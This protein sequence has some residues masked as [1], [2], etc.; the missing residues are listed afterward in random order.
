[1]PGCGGYNQARFLMSL[2]AGTSLGPYEIVAPVGAGGMGEVYRARDTRLG[3]DVAIKILPPRLASDPSA[4]ARFEQEARAV[5]ALSHPNIL[6]IHDVGRHDAIAFVVIELLDGETLRD[7]MAHGRVPL[8]KAVEYAVQM[9]QG[10]AAAHTKGITHRD[11]KPENVFVTNDGHVKILDF[12]LAKLQVMRATDLTTT[13]HVPTEPGTVLGT[14]GYLSPEQAQGRPV[15]PRSDIFSLG[16]VL[17][18]MATGVRAFKGDSTID[19]LHRII[20]SEPAP[21]DTVVPDAPGE[22]RWVL[23]KCLAKDPDDRYQSTRDLV[24]D[25]RNVMRALESS[26]RVSAA[27]QTMEAVPMPRRFSG[28][29]TAVIAAVLLVAAAVP[30]ALWWQSRGAGA[31][32]ADADADAGRLS[33]EPVTTLGTVIDAV[34][35]PDGK[36]VA[37]VVSENAQQSLW[38][39]Q[40][41]TASTLQ[42]VP[43]A[44]VGYWGANFSLDGSTL[45]Y[46]IASDEYPEKALFRI[47][48]LG[49]A[50]RKL[51]TGLDSFPVFAPDGRQMAYMRASYPEPGASALMVASID[52]ANARALATR[53]AP[54][55]F[56]P[57]FFTAPAWSPDGTM[58]VCPMVRRGTPTTATL[59]AVKA[60]DGSEMPFPHYEWA[61]IG[62]ATWMPDGTGLV[63]VGG[64]EGTRSR[65]NQLWWVSAR[66]VSR[67]KITNDLLDYRTV[68]LPADGSTIMTVAA[69]ATSS[70]WSAPLDGSSDVRRISGGRYDGLAGLA[71]APG[72]RIVYRSV[73]GGS[74]DLWIMEA[75]GTKRNPLTAEGVPASPALTPDGLSIVFE[76]EDDGLWQ[77]GLDG[78]GLRPV[79]ETRL[80][81]SPAVTPDGKWILY[82]VT[83]SGQE[84]LWKVPADGSAAPSRMLDTLSYGPAVSPDGTRVAFYFRKSPT[85]PYQLAVMRLDADRPEMTF[86][87]VPSS[88]YAGVRWTFDGKALLHNS[89]VGDRSNIWLQP[90]D[91]SPARKVTNFVDQNIM[92]FDRSVDGKRLIIARGVLSRDAVMIRHFR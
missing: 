68:S 12:G 48:I 24:V 52:G 50:A 65:P 3:R 55:F 73:E 43:P 36:Y 69:D 71:A 7:R 11:I 2:A 78:Q 41:A 85:S 25:L 18:E 59:V 54:E 29:Q 38:L 89:S 9:A 64:D 15:D 8:R 6:A 87:V 63:V 44:T 34:I 28:V 92:F 21:I 33:I 13:A 26:P 17:Y 20:H 86:S 22:L 40:L 81:Q 39:R 77:V 45:Y 32:V 16:A 19:S 23:A 66:S 10:L 88:A 75:D 27:A 53:K 42:L 47:S 30:T 60:T 51:L 46:A 79:K 61:S 80:A 14:V 67:R 91:G 82:G 72:G 37:Y 83:T 49:G 31:G 35:S 84:Q 76:R 4:V 90:L 56:V 62:Q 5:A 1:M 58:I 74:P 70:I 57:I